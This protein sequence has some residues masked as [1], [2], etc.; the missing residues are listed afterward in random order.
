MLKRFLAITCI[1]LLLQLQFVSSVHAF[2]PLLAAPAAGL[3]GGA[4][5]VTIA[6]VSIYAS[7]ERA[8]STVNGLVKRVYYSTVQDNQTLWG[9]GFALFGMNSLLAKVKA[10]PATFPKV[11]A[12]VQSNSTISPVGTFNYE[13]STSTAIW[14]AQTI[15][16]NATEANNAA[17]AALN[18]Y[19]T[20]YPSG[21]GGSV[22]S[23]YSSLTYQG[24]Q[25]FQHYAASRNV[26][27]TG[28]GW[29]TR[30]SRYWYP[31]NNDQTKI[32]S[33]VN[34]QAIASAIEADT[35][36]DSEVNAVIAA[37]AAASSTASVVPTTTTI[38]NYFTSAQASSLTAF[39]DNTTADDIT[40]YPP[41][42]APSAAGTTTTPVDT[43]TTTGSDATLSDLITTMKTAIIS[44]LGLTE[45][46]SEPLAPA[47]DGVVV[48]PD[49]SVISTLFDY[50]VVNSP[51]LALGSRIH[52]TTNNANC[53]VS[54]IV[55]FSATGNSNLQGSLTKQID[56]DFCRWQD[57][58][59]WLGTMFVSLAHCFAAFII[60]GKR[61]N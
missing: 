56:L 14:D 2:S 38:G 57:T 19:M 11:S 33:S 25:D 35:T 50:I 32:T 39:T 18:N 5:L 6:G 16:A 12:I 42:T 28:V 24:T 55:N 8:R 48:I 52:I 27:V 9:M 54:G 61:E 1:C 49:K 30:W 10:S 34:P 44:A 53:K 26:Y 23:G 46:P 45:A 15:V 59:T 20:L 7:N 21:T 22:S 41:F 4:A 36:T 13:T 58:F 29:T 51:L 17:N 60:L 40:T 3:I 43:S 37:G 47:Y 31:K